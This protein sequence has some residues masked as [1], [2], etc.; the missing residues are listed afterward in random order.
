[1][2]KNLSAYYASSHPW[3]KYGLSVQG[4]SLEAQVSHDLVWTYLERHPEKQRRY[5]ET[6][7]ARK[8]WS[9]SGYSKEFM[10]KERYGYYDA[11]FEAEEEIL[12]AHP[13][14]LEDKKL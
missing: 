7:A 9:D 10:P 5:L 13:E 11:L 6:D 4:Y 3:H 14:Y 2:R 8:V 1:M 12:K